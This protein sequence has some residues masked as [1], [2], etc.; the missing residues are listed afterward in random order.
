MCPD[1][2]QT[3]RLFSAWKEGRKQQRG[4]KL[5]AQL[6][7]PVIE[8]IG[9]DRYVQ[10]QKGSL[11]RQT[12]VMRLDESGSGALPEDPGKFRYDWS[13]NE[14]DEQESLFR[15]KLKLV[16]IG[17]NMG[18]GTAEE[19]LYG[20]V[21]YPADAATGT[22]FRVGIFECPVQPGNRFEEI[23]SMESRTITII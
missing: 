22:Y 8:N 13:G 15:A 1:S 7:V 14:Q 5:E 18:N 20:I 12:K 19:Q 4:L 6:D 23:K 16:V 2:S 11:Q 9:T 17:S 10:V 3:T 21:A